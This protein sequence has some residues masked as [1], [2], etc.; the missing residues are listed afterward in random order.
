MRKHSEETKRGRTWVADGVVLESHLP[1]RTEG[2]ELALG[3]PEL[4]F[5]ETA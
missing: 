2:D 1:E 4:V 3:A 5:F